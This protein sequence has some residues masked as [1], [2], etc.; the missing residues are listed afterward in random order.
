MWAIPIVVLI[1]VFVFTAPGMYPTMIFQSDFRRAFQWFFFFDAGF[2]L[3]EYATYPE[4]WKDTPNVILMLGMFRQFRI[5]VPVYVG[6]GYSFGAWLSLYLN[7]RRV[8]SSKLKE[9]VT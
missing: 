4:L 3:P 7:R 2:T 5:L 6:V 8:S 1:I 9:I